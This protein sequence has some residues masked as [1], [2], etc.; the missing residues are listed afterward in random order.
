[1]VPFKTSLLASGT[2]AVFILILLKLILPPISTTHNYISQTH[3]RQ[4][5]DLYVQREIISSTVANDIF[6]TLT[7]TTPTT[8]T[9]TAENF[10]AQKVPTLSVTIQGKQH[11]LSRTATANQVSA[12]CNKHGLS[13]KSC[14]NLVSART[15]EMPEEKDTTSSSSSSSSSSSLPIDLLS[16]SST[17]TLSVTISGI[18]HQLQPHAS[19]VEV[20][21]FCALHKININDCV[22]L[23][24]SRLPHSEHQHTK[25]DEGWTLKTTRIDE[26]GIAHKGHYDKSSSL[27]LFEY[28]RRLRVAT[29]TN[30]DGGRGCISKQTI[31]AV[32]PW[33]HCTS[34]PFYITLDT[35]EE[36]VHMVTF[37]LENNTKNQKQNSNFPIDAAVFFQ[38][39]PP[40]PKS[41]IIVS[42]Q[43]M[44]LTNKDVS[45]IMWYFCSATTVYTTLKEKEAC[46]VNMLVNLGRTRSNLINPNQVLHGAT[47]TSNDQALSIGRTWCSIFE[48]RNLP[49]SNFGI[50]G[51]SLVSFNGINTIPVQHLFLQKLEHD[52]EQFYY[53]SQLQLDELGQNSNAFNTLATD[54]RNLAHLL[55]TK[56]FGQKSLDC[57]EIGT[58]LYQE[59]KIESHRR[60]ALAYNR[61][62]FQPPTSTLLTEIKSTVR[63]IQ[64]SSSTSTLKEMQKEEK[65]YTIEYDAARAVVVDDLLTDEALAELR[66]ILASSMS[67][68]DVRP[69]FLGAYFNHD[70]A[71]PL[72]V[73][74][75]HDIADKYSYIVCGRSIKQIW[76]YKYVSDWHR[77]METVGSSGTSLHADSASVNVNIWITPDEANLDASSGGL[78]LWEG[79]RAPSDMSFEK[80]NQD[81]VAV[82]KWLDQGPD[83]VRRVVP[84][85][86]NRMVMFDSQLFH[87]TDKMRFKDGYKNR[88]INLTFLYGLA[89]AAKGNCKKD[90]NSGK[91]KYFTE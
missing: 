50:E 12:F 43:Q 90:R 61:V 75:A 38:V 20:A 46:D 19:D 62:L 65:D 9:T 78:V 83:T 39:L 45:S 71:H 41:N 84:Y 44:N 1:M 64:S 6:N 16:S 13:E 35:T 7:T 29:P 91:K 87:E 51:D 82:R 68:M 8:T 67:Y 37:T 49:P 33:T 56:D 76:S 66:H 25:Q 23:A 42:A 70:L 36:R 52:A 80:Y 2:C 88:R 18:T 63:R 34:L 4:T 27:P 31:D 81:P 53:I 85:K 11:T 55:K 58:F 3:A 69:G 26:S 89:G 22:R 30:H 28:G 17:S 32:E 10:P 48:D 77:G 24:Q 59:L 57:A 21:R 54:Y 47:L 40:N 74:I 60:I 73:K 86:S 5:L 14:T 15:P 72:L 79:T